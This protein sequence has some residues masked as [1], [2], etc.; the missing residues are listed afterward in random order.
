[1]ALE[2][3]I[4]GPGLDVCRR[5]RRGEPALIV[6]RDTDC[7]VCLPDPERNISR[8]HLS[9]WNDAEE[10]HFHVLSVVNGVDTASGALPPGSRGV[11]AAGDTLGLSA[12]RIRVQL[13]P[14]APDETAAAPDAWSEFARAAAQ[15]VPDNS[16][17]TVPGTA[18]ADPFGDWGFQS[19]FGAGAASSTLGGDAQQPATDLHPFFAG[20]GMD[21]S[22]SMTNGDLEMLGRLTRIAMQGLLQ[23]AQVAAAAR[24]DDPSGERTLME[25]REFNPLRMDTPFEAKLSY[26]FGGEVAAAGLM[27]PDRAVAQ[28]A[29]ELAA[30]QR[31]MGDAVVEVVQKVLEDFE[32]EALKKRLLGGSTRMFESARAWDAFVRHYAE[33]LAANPG[34]TQQLLDR[35]FVRAYARALVRAKRNTPGRS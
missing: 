29:A 33:Q 22:Q 1:M 32:P 27:P 23:A 19:T 5:L 21:G 16:S 13:A 15:L 17:E 34:W 12:F 6:G 4:S 24:K 7:A 2:L 20:L 31:A 11:L 8:R 10:L 9:V 18:D 25:A 28:I 30:H 26:L 3:S 14:D 35:H